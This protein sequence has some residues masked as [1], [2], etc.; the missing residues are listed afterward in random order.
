MISYV[1]LCINYT[2]C[3]LA[4]IQDRLK[5]FISEVP[6]FKFSKTA[7]LRTLYFYQ[8]LHGDLFQVNALSICYEFVM[9]RVIVRLQRVQTCKWVV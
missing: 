1:N 3:H 5:A 7:R 9:R 6:M 2:T 4:R 8:L